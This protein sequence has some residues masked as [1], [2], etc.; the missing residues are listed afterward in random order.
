VTEEDKITQVLSNFQ[1]L[2]D[3]INEKGGHK[4]RFDSNLTAVSESNAYISAKQG[5]ILD[6]YALRNVYSHMQRGKYLASLTDYAVKSLAKLIK[7]IKYP[8]SALEIFAPKTGSGIYET[9]VNAFIKDVLSDMTENEYT[10]VPVWKGEKLVGTFAYNSFF[11]WVNYEL[12]MRTQP[13]FEKER[14][15]DINP[16]Y[17]NGNIVRFQFV[18]KTDPAHEVPMIFERS[19]KQRKRLDC[20]FVTENGNRDEKILAIVTPWDLYKVS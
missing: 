16:R 1:E 7:D 14:M 8:P 17:L 19:T 11:Q 13:H 3:I 20:I 5:E 15:G 18:R 9:E 12:Q 6:L 10:H 2:E 4:S